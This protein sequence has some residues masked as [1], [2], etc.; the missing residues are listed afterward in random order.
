MSLPVAAD[1]VVC[2]PLWVSPGEMCETRIRGQP[3]ALSLPN[4]RILARL[5]M[6]AGRVVSRDELYG[7]VS[8]R[9]LERRSRAI[10]LHIW[11]IR[12]ALGPLGRFLVTV[13]G[14]G[15]RVDVVGLAEAQ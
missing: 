8:S 1:A 14:R 11:R 2:G 9:P 10:D 4:Q 6:A 13:P 12:R 5:I 15:Y 3:V 7:E